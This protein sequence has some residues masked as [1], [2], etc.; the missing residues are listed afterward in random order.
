MG[1]ITC[2][3]CKNTWNSFGEYMHQS[4][5]GNGQ[6]PIIKKEPT[7]M[8]KPAHINPQQNQYT[9]LS[10]RRSEVEVKSNP[11]NAEENCLYVSVPKII[12]LD[13]Y[14]RGKK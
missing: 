9:K 5:C 13:I 1:R 8:A 7:E 12:K 6:C 14:P 4:P 2:K 10:V 11:T 3:L